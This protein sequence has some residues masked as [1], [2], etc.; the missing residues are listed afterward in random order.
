MDAPTLAAVRRH[1]G[2]LRVPTAADR[3]HKDECMLSFDSPESPD[4]LYVK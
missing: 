1:M 3:V 4:G 2:G